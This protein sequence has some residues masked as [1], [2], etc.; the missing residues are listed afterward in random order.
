[1]QHY[2]VNIPYMLNG[3]SVVKGGVYAHIQVVTDIN[4]VIFHSAAT[5]II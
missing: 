5:H 2:M 3:L 4:L 1:M